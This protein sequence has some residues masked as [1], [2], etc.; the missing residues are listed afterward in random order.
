MRDETVVRYQLRISAENMAG[1]L[2]CAVSRQTE[3]K[4]EHFVNNDLITT[5]ET[6][7]EQFYQTLRSY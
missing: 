7:E 3:F 5:R 1:V 2:L 6:N 4:G